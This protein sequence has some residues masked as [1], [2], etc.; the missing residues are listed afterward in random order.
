MRGHS[1]EKNPIGE[2]GLVI[3]VSPRVT[4]LMEFQPSDTRHNLQLG[5]LGQ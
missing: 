5:Q 2:G 3:T 1:N 4:W